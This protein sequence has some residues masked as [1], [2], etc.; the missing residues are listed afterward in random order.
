MTE[1][2]FK[3]YGM[4]VKAINHIFM[5]DRDPD[6]RA[7]SLLSDVQEMLELIGGD[8]A[9]REQARKTLN[10]AKYIMFE[11]MDRR[12]TKDAKDPTRPQVKEAV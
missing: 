11:M 6:W 9:Y 2:E 12:E 7:A 8:E 4:S 3:V 1:K 5:Q 10:V